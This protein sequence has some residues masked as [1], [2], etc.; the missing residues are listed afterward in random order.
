MPYPFH[1]KA[2]NNTSG[3]V[4]EV[5]GEFT[6]GEWS[7]A[8]L[9]L[10]AFT[11][12]SRCRIAASQSQLSWGFSWQA[13]EAPEFRASLPPDDDIDAFLHRMRP[14]VLKDAPTCFYRVRNTLARRMPLEAV[15]KYLDRMKETYKGTDM[16]FS[17]DYNDRRL[18]SDE[19][20]DL[21]LNAF[22]YHQDE[23]KRVNIRTMFALFPEPTARALFLQM[24]LSRAAA[25]QQLAQV[26]E[27]LRRKDGAEGLLE[28]T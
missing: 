15:R 10:E 2:K 7:A 18:T 1:V 16:G 6:D 5:Q 24:M 26:L 25:V 14:F 12:L 28:A 11:R 22:E 13:G 8:L 3:V 9:Y 19:A 27:Q 23:N 4:T 21:W 17:I 20:V